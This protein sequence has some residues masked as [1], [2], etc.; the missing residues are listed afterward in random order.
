N[1]FANVAGIRMKWGL[2]QVDPNTLVK[3]FV[4]SGGNT[5]F[6]SDLPNQG[7]TT[8]E[9]QGFADGNQFE[10]LVHFAFNID[11]VVT[12]QP[13]FYYAFFALVSHFNIPNT[14]P[15]SG[16]PNFFA[17]NA[18]Y[19]TSSGTPNNGPP[20]QLHDPNVSWDTSGLLNQ[21]ASSQLIPVVP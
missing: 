3:N 4:A 19:T 14:V 13:G 17:E 10:R 18:V 1:Y 2:L 15:N 16:G 11:N 5:L 7:F 6:P 9:T 12:L 20:F 8:V 21:L